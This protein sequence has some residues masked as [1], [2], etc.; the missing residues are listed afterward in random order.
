MADVQVEWLDA[1][2]LEPLEVEIGLARPLTVHDYRTAGDPLAIV[3]NLVAGREAQVWAE[4]G[5]PPG[6]ASQGRHELE[7]A[8]LLVIWTL[9]PSPDLLLAALDRVQP[10]EVALFAHQ[11][12]MGGPPESPRRSTVWAVS[13]LRGM[14]RFALEQKDGWIHLERAAARVAQRTS[15]VQVGL[16]W[17]AA[18]GKIVIVQKLDDQWQLAGEG[19]HPDPERVELVQ[20]RMEAIM[21]ETQAYREY[22]R[23]APASSLLPGYQVHEV[24]SPFIPGR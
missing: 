9:P 22:A 20:Q 12:E 6:I 10:E 18:Q 2:L 7:S 5:S 11:P 3:V 1:R 4:A 13:M 16:E 19:A 8:P 21:V 14:V 15:F 17:L 23:G 24:A